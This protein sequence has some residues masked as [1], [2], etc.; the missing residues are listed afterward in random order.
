MFINI[1]DPERMVG[2]S[3][4]D[5]RFSFHQTIHYVLAKGVL[6]N[7]PEYNTVWQVS[8]QC[9]K[10]NAL[11]KLSA[12]LRSSGNLETESVYY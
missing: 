12:G 11:G 1:A 3:L 2:W 5:H 9:S 4:C 8:L 7:H 10:E 6:E